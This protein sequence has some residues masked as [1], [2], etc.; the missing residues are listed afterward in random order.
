MVLPWTE[1]RF[2]PDGNREVRGDGEGVRLRS[3]E[4]LVLFVCGSSVWRGSLCVCP[5]VHGLV[6]C[7]GL[8]LCLFFV[9]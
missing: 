6:S 2:K 1:G 7:R 9:Q 4:L 5:Q 8:E 3:I